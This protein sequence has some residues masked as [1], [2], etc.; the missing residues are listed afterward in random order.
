M[1]LQTDCLR[2][3][4]AKPTTLREDKIKTASKLVLLVAVVRLTF[5]GALDSRGKELRTGDRVTD[6]WCS[7]RLP[8]SGRPSA[9][10]QRAVDFS[11]GFC[12]V[13]V[14]LYIFLV[15]IVLHVWDDNYYVTQR[16]LI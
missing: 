1:Q 3:V 15:D 8:E 7:L 11:P 4:G 12:R 10:G 5:S 9:G 13:H 16:N 6:M 14:F 2:S